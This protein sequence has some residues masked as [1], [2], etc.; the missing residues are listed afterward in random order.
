MARSVVTAAITA[1][2]VVVALAGIAKATDSPS[3]NVIRACYHSKTGALR[4]LD[5]DAT[6]SCGKHETRLDWNLQGVPGLPGAAGV[7]GYQIVTA[8]GG[9]DQPGVVAGSHPGTTLDYQ[10]T[11][12][13]TA[14]CPPGKKVTGGGVD[15][16]FAP[17]ITINASY[18][19]NPPGQTG[20]SAQ[21]GG[22]SGY[23]TIDT[24]LQ[25]NRRWTIKVWAFCATV[26]P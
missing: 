12:S 10:G 21:D 1:G 4:I 2:A 7:S 13:A 24:S 9:S 3:D 22:W 16:S 19:Q 11:Q 5:A 20:A 6:D 8:E 25:G 14:Y 26:T 18:P 15:V 17:G 23:A